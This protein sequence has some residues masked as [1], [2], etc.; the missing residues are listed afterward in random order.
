MMAQTHQAEAKPH[1]FPIVIIKMSKWMVLMCSVWETMSALENVSGELTKDINSSTSNSC[2]RVGL[3]A[4]MAPEAG[5]L[6]QCL[7]MISAV[8]RKEGKG[9]E[10]KAA[11][12]NRH[13]PLLD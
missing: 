7:L 13:H 4:G 8:F 10:K 12:E 1:S 2:T 3:C 5:F 9:V 11:H 6:S